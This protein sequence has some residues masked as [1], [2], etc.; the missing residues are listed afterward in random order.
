MGKEATKEKEAPAAQFFRMM[1]RECDELFGDCKWRADHNK[2]LLASTLASKFWWKGQMDYAHAIFDCL[3]GLTREREE[4]LAAAWK[5]GERAEKFWKKAIPEPEKLERMV[6][7]AMNEAIRSYKRESALVK[8]IEGKAKSPFTILGAAMLDAQC[9]W[10]LDPAN[11]DRETR[12]EIFDRWIALLVKSLEVSAYLSQRP[13]DAAGR[14]AE[15]WQAD[16]EKL[17]PGY[18]PEYSRN[19]ALC[20]S[21]SRAENWEQLWQDAGE[22]EN[23]VRGAYVPV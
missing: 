19:I 12:K 4:E 6:M 20:Y 16:C 11:V 13:V 17:L 15:I 5:N 2:S 9:E 23:S 1:D 7:R 18:K 10:Q 14:D 22:V 3:L 21:T 8:A